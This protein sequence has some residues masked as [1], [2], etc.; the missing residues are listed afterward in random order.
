MNKVAAEYGCNIL[1]GVLS[2]IVKKYCIDG[3]KVII[4]KEVPL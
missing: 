1:E 2:H 3:N 4:G